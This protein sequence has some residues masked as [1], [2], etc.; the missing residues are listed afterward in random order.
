MAEKVFDMEF[1]DAK[2]ILG[3]Y[4]VFH[5]HWRK[6]KQTSDACRPFQQT[7][8]QPFHQLDT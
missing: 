5:V 1:D 6:F 8:P 2:I 7:F 3:I 4:D